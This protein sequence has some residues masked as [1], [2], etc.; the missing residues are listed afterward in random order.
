MKRVMVMVV[1]GLLLAG[2]GWA[3][4]YEV[5]FGYNADPAAPPTG[6]ALYRLAGDERVVVIDDIGPEARSFVVELPDPDP[7]HCDTYAM[8]ALFGEGRH[9]GPYSRAYP[10]CPQ[11]PLPAG[12]EVRI[13]GSAVFDVILRRVDN[14]QGGE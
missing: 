1:A 7:L 6:F 13:S 8:A 2:P 4:E 10:L 5:V 14:V 12:S 9:N 11:Y 3:A